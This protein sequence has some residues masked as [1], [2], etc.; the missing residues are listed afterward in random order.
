MRS[1]KTGS[2]A[3]WL[4]AILL[5]TAAFA[6]FRADR[7]PVDV[8]HP[9]SSGAL[10]P[11][12]VPQ[13][14]HPDLR[15]HAGELRARNPFRFERAPTA[16]AYSIDEAAPLAMD[17]AEPSDAPH[18]AGVLSLG[19]IFGGPPWKALIEGMAGHETGVVLEVGEQWNGIRVEW[20]RNDSVGLATADS[21]WP[22]AMK[23]P[24]R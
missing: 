18:V 19:G 11:P 8:G 13:A 3:L 17:V 9:A 6:T 2:Y 4:A 23:Q 1:P 14:L 15:A 21:V 16:Q 24:W 10:P 7:Q 22:L 20:I 12:A 5:M